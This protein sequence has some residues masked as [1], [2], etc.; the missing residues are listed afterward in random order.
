MKKRVN[1]FIAGCSKTGTTWLYRCLK[2]HP[3]VFVPVRDSLH[4]FSINYYW[5]EPWYHQWFEGVEGEKIICDPTPSNIRP[6]RAARRIFDYNPEA[7]LLFTLRNPVERSFSHYWH[8]K[9]KGLVRF[10]FSDTVDYAGVGNFDLFEIWIKSSFY[11]EQLEPFFEIFPR[12]QL[13]IKLYD[14]L[15]EDSKKYLDDILDFLQIDRDF[16]PSV[17]DRKVNSAKKNSRKLVSDPNLI[18][19]LKT[20]ARTLLYNNKLKS[21]LNFGKKTQRDIPNEYEIGVSGELRERLNHIFATELKD[22]SALIGRDLS[23][24]R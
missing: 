22:L 19:R 8:Q 9:R 14:E 6:S 10:D 3:E 2:E 5:G 16:T 13:R 23:H 24:W 12:E 11:T 21:T 1:F 18:R 17:L 4:Y 15:V 20:T 7:K